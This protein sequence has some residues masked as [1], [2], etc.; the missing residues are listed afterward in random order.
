MDD[1]LP[2]LQITIHDTTSSDL[3]T[4]LHTLNTHHLTTDF[5]ADDTHPLTDLQAGHTYVTRA[6]ADTAEHLATT[7]ITTAP[8]TVFELVNDPHETQ[9]GTYIGHVPNTGT[10]RAQCNADGVPLVPA[11]DLAQSLADAPRTS[12]EMWLA[13]TAPGLLGTRVRAALRAYTELVRCR[14]CRRT[15]PLA[16][17]YPHAGRYVCPDC[18]D[19]RLYATA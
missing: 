15:T 18:W 11:D 4:V 12:V 2:A 17:A 3:P 19:D 5:T 8:H 13:T 1:N 6:G 7:L 16:T 14:F 9:E 10:F